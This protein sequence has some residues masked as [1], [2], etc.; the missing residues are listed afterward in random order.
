MKKLFILSLLMVTF[1]IIGLAQPKAAVNDAKKT[2][3]SKAEPAKAPKLLSPE[4]IARLR[5]AQ[6][7]REKAALR[8]QLAR[9]EY[10]QVEAEIA[11]L[12]RLFAL[13][14]KINIEE[15]EIDLSQIAEGVVGF[16]PKA[17]P[18]PLKEPEKKD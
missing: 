1:S 9:T 8:V 13:E 11:A 14:Q 17:K 12:V 15:Y 7:V 3:E 5:Q 2:T 6:E 16:K 4:Q 10:A 18:E